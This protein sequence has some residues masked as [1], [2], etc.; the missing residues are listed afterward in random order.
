[1]AAAEADVS[2]LLVMESIGLELNCFSGLL[3]CSPS[4]NLRNVTLIS[5]VLIKGQS[6]EHEA[7]L[8]FSLL[9]SWHAQIVFSLCSDVTLSG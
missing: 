2:V 6:T 9:H 3:I 4:L 8:F 7:L 5:Q 1:M